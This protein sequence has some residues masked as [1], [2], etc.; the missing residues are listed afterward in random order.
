MPSRVRD[1]Q[2]KDLEIP[3]L[4]CDPF[5]RR[6]AG[7]LLPVA[8]EMRLV[9]VAAL[10]R[11]PGNVRPPG[12]GVSLEDAT[13]AVEP[14]HPRCRLGAQPDLAGEQRAEVPLAPADVES[15]VANRHRPAGA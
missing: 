15:D 3:E 11:D 2:P 9:E 4:G 7:E 14:D 6:Q 8:N 5:G 10:G 1:A 13:G 12:A